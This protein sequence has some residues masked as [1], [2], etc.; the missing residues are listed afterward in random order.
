VASCETESLSGRTIPLLILPAFAQ[1]RKLDVCTEYRRI[2]KQFPIRTG[3]GTCAWFSSCRMVY[4]FRFV[5]FIVLCISPDPENSLSL[6]LR[7]DFGARPVN[8]ASIQ[9]IS[10]A[11]T[12]QLYSRGATVYSDKLP[13]TPRSRPTSVKPGL[14]TVTQSYVQRVVLGQ[15]QSITRS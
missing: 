4:D 5:R 2:S 7:F 6:R 10:G 3:H 1:P 9:P 11:S 12:P 14:E 13:V 8:R 15:R